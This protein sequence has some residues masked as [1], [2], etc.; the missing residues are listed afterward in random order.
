MYRSTAHSVTGKSPTELLFNRKILN[1]LSTMKERE[2]E[3]VEVRDRNSLSK[4][5]SSKLITVELKDIH[6]GDEVMLKRPYRTLAEKS[7]LHHLHY[8]RQFLT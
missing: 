8:L 7:L 2:E 6:V 4:A 3:L 1:K 5:K